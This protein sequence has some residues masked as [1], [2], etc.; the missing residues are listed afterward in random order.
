MK[1]NRLASYLFVAAIL[2]ILS[3]LIVAYTF[4]GEVLAIKG[5]YLL[6]G[7]MLA[8]ILY[9]EQ[10]KPEVD[11]QPTDH[12]GRWS[13]KI[14]S[15]L[16]ISAYI[17]TYVI[18]ARLEMVVLTLM[19][20]YSLVAYQIL[21]A[22]VTKALVPQIALLFTVGPVTKYLST[23]FYFGATDLLGHVRAVE[24]L[25]QT[26]R[27]ESI[28]RA[29]S[30][31]DSFPALHILSGAISSFT[32]LSAYDSLIILGIFTYTVVTIA[33]FYLSQ[34]IFSLSK[35]IMITLVFSVLSVVHNYTTYF[36]PQALATALIIFLIYIT[37]RRQS[38]PDSEYPLLSL[39]AVLVSICV[40]ITHHVT[41]LILAGLVSALYAPSILRATGLGQRLRVNRNLPR[42]IP[43]LFALT[44]GITYLFIISP[45]T[46]NYFAQF[47]TD[48]I[49]TL[50][51]SDTGGG[52]AVVGL[53]TEIPY[54][55][56]RIAVKSLL[57]I[58]G[59]YYIGIT[60][61]FSVGV[62]VTVV[63]YDQYA[64]VAGL[65]LL[66]IGSS[67]AVLKTPLPDTVSRLSLPLAFFFSIIVGVGL[68]QLVGKDSASNETTRWKGLNKKRAA[69]FTLIVLVGT[70]GPLVA[71]DDLYGLH[72]GPNLWETYSTPE[73]Q[74]EFSEQ[75]LD[76][77][78]TMVQYVDQHTSEATMLWVS[79]EA[80]DRF[81]GEERRAPTHISEEG[82]RTDSPLVY[83]TNWINHQVGYETDELGT[84]MIA[85]W[86][87]DREIDA[88]NK[89]YTTGMVG[90]VGTEDGTYLSVDRDSTID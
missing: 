42:F 54:H 67:L 66:G 89:V 10:T 45:T 80:S 64:N 12:L 48:I 62:V 28:A 44:A 74:V 15:I 21:F 77:F 56:P 60:A 33:V 51:V 57:S 11:N 83:R 27:L 37:I 35:S 65:T 34:S 31:Y 13:I 6:I 61:L 49:D 22:T 79:R 16:I 73:Q 23:G 39:A 14:I 86:W 58:D 78:E 71:A 41:Q 76:E 75:E 81:G 40:V 50:F 59:V 52:R 84:L 32:G 30:T 36:F 85:D 8:A 5:S 43:I 2:L 90:V 69:V 25:Y 1:T 26:G 9:Q 17:V 72:A 46:V 19:L 87:L 3:T 7:I 20:G 68:W 88:S 24:L 29:Y 4:L 38:V 47:T 63:A 55:T 18:G 82:I 70:T 53:G